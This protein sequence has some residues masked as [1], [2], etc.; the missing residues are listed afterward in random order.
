MKYQE[1]TILLP[2]H[3]LEDF[4][5]HHEGDDA[6]GLL[7][8]WSALWHPALLAGAQSM[9]TWFRADSPP[10]DLAGRLIVIPRVSQSE[11]ATGFAQRAER[12]AGCLIQG[13]IRRDE[14]VEEALRP[15]DESAWQI[16]PS[17]VADFLALGYC[18]LQVE[19][20]TRQM[21]Y[22]SNLD[23]IHFQGLVLA[24]V[25]GA[26]QDDEK[27]AREKLQECFDVLSE[28]R[29][30][31]YP[32]EGFILDL[33]L[34]APTTIGRTLREQLATEVACNV[35]LS[36]DTLQMIADQEPATLQALQKAIQEERL[37]LV[38]S[39]A[40]ES[41]LPLL[42]CETIAAQLQET[43][44]RF[45]HL[46]GRRPVVY[47]R[48]R[49]GLTPVLPQILKQLG[50]EACLHFTL[51]DGSFPE[52]SQVKVRWEGCDGTTL[53]AIARAPIDATQSKAFLNYGVKTGESMDMD[54]VASICLAH[55]PG[56]PSTWYGD[57]RHI[58]RYGAAL[59][60]FVTVEHYFQNT[61]LPVHQD[62]FKADQYRSPYCA[63]SVSRGQIDPISSSVRY[64][65]GRATT[66]AAKTLE[67][68][69][70]LLST[71]SVDPEHSLAEALAN[72]MAAIDASEEGTAENAEGE[73]RNG[74]L[75][76]TAVENLAERLPRAKEPAEP[77]CL[78]FNP[79]SFVRR[80]GIEVPDL[81]GL[82]AVERPIYAASEQDR[83]KY[84]VA[85]VPPAGFVW[86]AK[87]GAAG[88][89]RKSDQV[90]ADT[91]LLHNEF[92]EAKIDPDTGTLR[93][94]SQ[95]EARGT[96]ISQQLAMRLGKSKR[97]KGGDAW[98]DPYESELYSVMAADSVETTLA[99]SAVGE[100]ACRGRLL[101]RDGKELA[102]FHQTYRIWRGSRVLLIDIQL[103]PLAECTKDAWNS[104][105]A[106]RFAW[107]NE[108]ATLHRSVN[109]TRQSTTAKRIE[110][111]HYVEIDDGAG[112]IAILTGGLPYHRRLGLRMMDSLLV[113]R[114]ETCRR[115]RLGIGVDLKL[116]LQEAL[117]LLTPET[118]ISQTA[119]PP[120]PNR[121]GWLF[122]L[123]SRNVTA[124]DWEP[125]EEQSR[126]IGCRV[127]LLETG[128]RLAKV[129]LSAFRKIQSARR[130]DLN[131][132]S[133]QECS[134]EEDRV[135]L[136]LSA[137]QWVQ[138]E[139]LW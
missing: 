91:C 118:W 22:S 46:L 52:G 136:Q 10:E 14:I 28:E 129:G 82:P 111:P 121:S 44:A 40:A 86:V 25:D 64:W 26:V 17:L 119:P 70:A 12:D 79:H 77:G 98:Q 114:G 92:F 15:L 35:V 125:L 33:T 19:L 5:T 90:L 100:I 117:G 66:E 76:A 96:R 128:G 61:D 48:R 41:R 71:E 81:P 23:E 126:V 137:H 109:L 106:A 67:T 115:F 107:A 127:R 8:N 116:P 7:A 56:T 59:G 43:V 3:S 89:Q 112:R 21:R 83:T 53:D 49:F 29:D 4:P 30:H 63:Q 131:G 113:V 42:S 85:D 134:I 135:R 139:I 27:L 2:C 99:T 84:V 39:E 87:G 18:Y 97:R 1:L 13:R 80:I 88:D 58:A 122:H 6:E 31:Y 51:E 69:A 38:A 95:Y 37:G 110:A 104:Y 68:F 32:V 74:E 16:N 20:L 9:P 47:G 75:L 138:L 55:W 65:R 50:F 94:I 130:V 124:T 57:L 11:L 103:E 123:D 24:A 45:E 102:T 34:V 78:V 105:F 62:K 120:A 101:D 36:G 108:A 72:R 73:A 133:P 60:R 54:H 93:S 132:D